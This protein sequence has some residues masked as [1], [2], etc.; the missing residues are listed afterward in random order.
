M[1]L[2][3]V[4]HNIHVSVVH[5]HLNNFTGC[6]IIVGT[7]VLG[8][9]ASFSYNIGGRIEMRNAHEEHE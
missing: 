1:P 8:I 4:V 2:Q 5:K 9:H 7:S 6:K 3:V